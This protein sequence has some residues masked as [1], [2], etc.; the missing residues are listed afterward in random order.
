MSPMEKHNVQDY[1]TGNK[2]KKTFSTS[3]RLRHHKMI[4]WYDKYS[5]IIYF[6]FYVVLIIGSEVVK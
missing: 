1:I 3:M 5:I 6:H 4:A 2:E